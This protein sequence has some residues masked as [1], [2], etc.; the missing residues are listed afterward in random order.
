MEV[1]RISWKLEFSNL[2]FLKNSGFL[3]IK[4]NFSCANE[5]GLLAVEIGPGAGL[6]ENEARFFGLIF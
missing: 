5:F 3:K 2:N 6:L 1:G 4:S